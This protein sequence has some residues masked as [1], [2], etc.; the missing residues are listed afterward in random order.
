MSP[1]SNS[2]ATRTAVHLKTIAFSA[3]DRGRA[4]RAVVLKR[5]YRLARI[6]EDWVCR[7]ADSDDAVAISKALKSEGIDFICVSS[8][9]AAADI[10]NPSEPGYNVPIAA[11]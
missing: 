11:R 3:V 8:G 10:R 5:R 6:T 2:A 1:I 7:R 4:V 9:G